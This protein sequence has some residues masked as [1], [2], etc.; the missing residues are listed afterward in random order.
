MGV[1]EY[2]RIELLRD[3]FVYAYQKSASR[4]VV[5]KDAV[6]EPNLFRLRYRREIASAVREIVTGGAPLSRET[7]DTHEFSGVDR[8]DRQAFA[9]MLL[10][11]LLNLHEGNILRY[12]LRPSEF[13]AW[14]KAQHRLGEQE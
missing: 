12:R 7:V 11:E 9:D 13:D 8:I 6:V 2:N 10:E 1:Y 5:I 4:F 14:D 3:I